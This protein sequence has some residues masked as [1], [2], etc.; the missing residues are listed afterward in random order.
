MTI[1]PKGSLVLC[2]GANGFIAIH[3]VQSLLGRG[4]S[5]RGTVRDEKKA[6]Y[7]RKTFGAFGD[8]L[9]VVVVEDITKVFSFLN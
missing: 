9:E 6:G 1:V 5:V 2:S 3:V 4:Y 7:L 8:K